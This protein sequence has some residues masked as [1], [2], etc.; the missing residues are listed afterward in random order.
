MVETMSITALAYQA[1]LY[2]YFSLPNWPWPG[3]IKPS[4]KIKP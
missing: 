3:N 4:V 1:W 2:G